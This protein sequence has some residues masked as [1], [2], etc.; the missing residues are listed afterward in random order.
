MPGR[1]GV[2]GNANQYYDPSNGHTKEVYAGHI[3][4]DRKSSHQLSRC[5]SLQ[6][7][8]HRSAKMS[9]SPSSHGLYTP[10]NHHL[11]P[12][13]FERDGLADQMMPMMETQMMGL[14]SYSDSLVSGQTSDFVPVTVRIVAALHKN[15]FQAEGEWTCYRRNYMSCGCS[16]E[17]SPF[18]PAYDLFFAQNE[19]SQPT[20]VYGLAMT[21]SAVVAG[22]D[23]QPIILDL[24]TPKRDPKKTLKAQKIPMVPINAS[25]MD[26]R[27]MSAGNV[28]FYLRHRTPPDASSGTL[29]TELPMEHTFERVQFRQATQNN[30]KRRAAQQ[31]YHFVVELWASVLGKE[32][33][34]EYVRVASQKSHKMIVR[35]RS[36]GHY[37]NDKN[38][39]SAHGS[40]THTGGFPAFNNLPHTL[41]DFTSTSLLNDATSGYP[42]DTRGSLYHGSRGHDAGAADLH[43]F[44]DTSKLVQGDK[45]FP[46]FSNFTYDNDRVDMFHQ[47]SSMMGSMDL[48][49]KPKSERTNMFDLGSSGA[50]GTRT[51]G[52]RSSGLDAHSIFSGQ[53]GQ[54]RR[55][56]YS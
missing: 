47:P 53:D 44:P 28:P 43:L 4:N 55:P 31:F 32:G 7:P 38:K 37:Q 52:T 29:P 49:G 11:N 13:Q 2:R 5:P 35:G 39:S 50:S 42:Y 22:N 3:P 27:D 33:G 18:Y 16:F 8:G 34:Y 1:T 21:I 25:T 19:T 9:A 10:E 24:Y 30:G 23:Q 12:Q 14:L 6:S 45:P 15:F 40:N 56:E 41:P 17:L 54:D 20:L 48:Y 51:L 36:P 26:R 46:S